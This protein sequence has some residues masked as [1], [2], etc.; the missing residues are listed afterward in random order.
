MEKL[1]KRGYFAF[2]LCLCVVAQACGER[3]VRG[4]GNHPAINAMANCRCKT[5]KTFWFFF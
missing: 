3:N 5:V 1:D 4:R 2:S